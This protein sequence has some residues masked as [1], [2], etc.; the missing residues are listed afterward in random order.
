[1]SAR[2][3]ARAAVVLAA[4]ASSARLASGQADEP[5]RARSPRAVGAE[6]GAATALDGGYNRYNYRYS[7]QIATTLSGRATIVQRLWRYGALEGSL[8]IASRVQFTGSYLTGIPLVTTDT[9]FTVIRVADDRDPARGNVV[10]AMLRAGVETPGDL[11]RA[12]L[13]AGVGRL[14]G[15]GVPVRTVRATALV[16]RGRNPLT[17]SLDGWWYRLPVLG[18]ESDVPQRR[19]RLPLPNARRELPAHALLLH[20]G[21]ETQLG[22]R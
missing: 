13:T 18:Y 17:V 5:R 10:P 7:S 11:L 12:R 6:L 20:V 3:E 19:I 8:G 15:V 21:W 9:P 14:V 1:M 4:V 16:G 2:F 22:G